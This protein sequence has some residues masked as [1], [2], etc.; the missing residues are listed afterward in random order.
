MLVSIMY[1]ITTMSRCDF[2]FFSYIE[3]FM[4]F[5]GSELQVE[6][7]TYSAAFD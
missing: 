4:F 5:F 7:P 2:L 3:S 1:L 6:D